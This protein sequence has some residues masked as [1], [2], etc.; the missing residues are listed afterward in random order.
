MTTNTLY[1]EPS[2]AQAFGGEV[3]QPSALS[4]FDWPDRDPRA[5]D[6]TIAPRSAEDE[7]LV[8][9]VS[10]PRFDLAGFR[11]RTASLPL[12]RGKKGSK[13][14]GVSHVTPSPNW[15]PAPSSV[16]QIKSPTSGSAQQRAARQP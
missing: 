5:I 4:A 3:L 1:S 7:R 12:P 9:T 11:R 14:E 2:I 15:K 16:N 8:D 13:E 6:Q 10:D